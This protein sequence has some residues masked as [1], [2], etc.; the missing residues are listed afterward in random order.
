QDLAIN[1]V[2][3]RLMT[4]GDM[5][6]NIGT[7]SASY[8]VPANGNASSEFASSCWI[9]GFDKQGQLKVAAQTYRQDGNDY[10][11]G[12]LDANGTITKNDCSNWDQFWKVNK[13]D[14]NQFIQLKKSGG[15]PTSNQFPTIFNWPAV[16]NPGPNKTGIVGATGTP[17]NLI[18]GR[19]YAPFV[20]VDGDGKYNPNNGDY[21]DIDGDQYIWWVFNDAGNNKLQSQT[22]AIG[23]EVQANSFAYSTNDA[24]NDATFIDYKIYNRGPIELDSAYMA[25][26]D[27]ADLGWAFDDYIG[28]DTSRGL[29]ID[30]NGKTEDG[31]GQPGTYGF[32]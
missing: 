15:A 25:V 26:W 11:P 30:Y 7:A 21:P 23:L 22:A 29:G 4:G 10:W 3:A 28:C 9:G 14:I 24:L 27:D 32:N 6:W 19:T 17:I 18:P 1:N 13:A 2:R 12:A 5:W 8:V 16:G 31:S 20:D